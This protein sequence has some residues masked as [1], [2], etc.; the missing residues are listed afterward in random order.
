MTPP[1]FVVPAAAIDDA[2]PGVDVRLDGPEGRHAVTVRRLAAGE[3]VRLVDGAGRYADATVAVVVDASTA[4]LIVVAAGREPEP[5]PR[6]VVVQAL[7]KGE[8]GELAVEVLTEVGT[9]VIIPWAAERCVAVWRGEKA[10]R[11]RRRWVDTAHAAAKQA[12]RAR[13]PVVEEL[14]T[15]VDVVAR[16]A[17]ASLALVLHEDAT[18]PIGDVALPAEGDVLLVVGP[19]GGISASER[20]EL[21]AAGAREVRLGPSVLRTSTAGVAAVSAVLAR[22]PRWRVRVPAA[23]A[24]ME[25]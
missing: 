6:I 11:G 9:D 1:V 7:P 16:V 14:A 8:R 12:R 15:T 4:D 10:V 20:E 3:P 19:E 22:S 25:P 17:T 5:A 24:R 21:S 13:F 18:D 2:R 23:D